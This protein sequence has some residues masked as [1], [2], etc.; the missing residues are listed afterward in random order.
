MACLIIVWVTGRDSRKVVEK[1][2]LMSNGAKILATANTDGIEIVSKQTWRLAAAGVALSAL[3]YAGAAYWTG[4]KA[5]ETLLEQHRMV[6]GLPLFTVQSHDYQRGWFSSSEKTELVLNRKLFEPY[7]NILPE[8]ARGMLDAKIVYTHHIKHGPLP[9]LTDFDLRP[10]RALVSTEFIMSD[11]TRKTLS[12][13]F[14]DADPITLTNRLYFSGGGELQ[15]AI[16]KFDYEETL[17][18]VK[19]RW[20][21]FH[22]K[23]DYASGYQ[24]YQID[25]RL[26][27]LEVDAAIKGHVEFKNVAFVSETTPGKTGVDIGNSELTIENIQLD[28]RE[29]V[30]YEI[31]LNELVYLLTRIRVG[32]FINPSGEIKPSKAELKKLRYRVNTEEDGEFVNTRGRFDFASLMINKTTVGPLEL[33]VSANHL[34]G[35]TLVK[36]DKALSAIPFEGKDPAELRRTYVDTVLREGAPLLKQDPIVKVNT[37]KLQLPDGVVDVSGQVALKAVQDADLHKAL[38]FL[39]KV[40]ADAKLSLPRQTLEDV[41]VAQARNLFMVDERAENPP[42]VQEIDD[43]AK[44]LFSSQLLQWREQGYVVIRGGQIDTA[45]TWDGQQLT[46]NKQPISLPWQEPEPE[47]EPD[48]SSAPQ[49]AAADAKK[50]S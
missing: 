23:V 10:A 12:K 47:P 22:G 45:L 7:L 49:D 2:D 36:L 30:P 37:L 48:T 38:D 6:A 11:A 9:G 4:L 16:P 46:V 14:G 17:S 18:G 31:R 21:G 8:Q 33:D 40:H 27:G 28:S 42:S 26:P 5:E 39:T 13:F 29:S 41:V 20:G 34:H 50:P 44:S 19:I 24:Q 25:A 3:C 32:E 1:H 43:L 35:P 15:V